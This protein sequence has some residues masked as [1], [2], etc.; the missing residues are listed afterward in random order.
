MKDTTQVL[1]RNNKIV[2]LSE[3]I[4][5]EE[6]S[7]V[8]KLNDDYNDE[9]L[10]EECS[11]SLS[12][13]SLSSHY[14]VSIDAIPSLSFEE[15]VRYARMVRSMKALDT[16]D[17]SINAQEVLRKGTLARQV[18]I[19]HNL[20]LV[21]SIARKYEGRGVLLDD[22]IQEGNIGLMEAVDKYNPEY[23]F[24]FST[25]AVH[26]IRQKI[27]RLTQD[28][29]RDLHIPINLQDKIAKIK[30]T[31]TFLL[32][33]LER[34]ATDV[35]VAVSIA[36]GKAC[37]I[38]ALNAGKKLVDL[39]EGVDFGE[40]NPSSIYDVLNINKSVVRIDI[41]IFE[42]DDREWIETISAPDKEGLN[43]LDRD[44]LRGILKCLLTILD[45]REIIILAY[46]YGLGGLKERTYEDIGKIIGL[47]RERVR[48]LE[49]ES[50]E[51][52]Q[53]CKDSYLLLPFQG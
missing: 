43:D 7:D 8:F 42:S 38:E 50:L 36:L 24:R 32:Q 18:L 41:P 30:S 1:S 28:Q 25:Y 4:H 53:S 23:G 20:R 19:E 11:L 40:Y 51:T 44:T 34:E 39:S 12:K 14:N 31:Q 16:N 29:G 52:L 5:T 2:F 48:Q 6:T 10:L 26:T 15:E 13:T 35:E 21:R 47:T 9:T 37:T 33:Y 22:L 46:R 3:D 27:K 17:K 45:Q 49:K